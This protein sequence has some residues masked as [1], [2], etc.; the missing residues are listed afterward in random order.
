MDPDATLARIRELAKMITDATDHGDPIH[1]HIAEHLAAQVQHL[2]EYM[3]RGGFPPSAWTAN[4][5]IPYPH[6]GYLYT[7]DL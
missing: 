6:P 2:D 4:R 1:A 3:T 5:E 7:G